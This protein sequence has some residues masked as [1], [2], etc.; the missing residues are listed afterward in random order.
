[1]EKDSIREFINMA[2]LG[3]TL[4]LSLYG[5]YKKKKNA[6]KAANNGPEHWESEEEDNVPLSEWTSLANEREFTSS[7]TP[8]PFA[9]MD[10]E[11]VLPNVTSRPTVNIKKVVT[12][13]NVHKPLDLRQAVIYSE[14]LKRKEF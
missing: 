6:A 2:L 14:I 11:P 4:L 9:N 8:P 5:S 12:K 3:G 13:K 7:I 10:K 1:M